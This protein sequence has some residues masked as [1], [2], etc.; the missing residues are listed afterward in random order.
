M[1]HLIGRGHCLRKKATT[2]KQYYTHMCLF[3]RVCVCGG[4]GVVY[5]CVWGGEGGQATPALA[6]KLLC[7]PIVT[8]LV[9][10]TDNNIS[11][12]S[13]D[14]FYVTSTEVYS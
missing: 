8:F 14:W 9:F 11:A 2:W 7:R 3:T 4:G 12:P 13:I 6:A 5:T 1:L 10:R